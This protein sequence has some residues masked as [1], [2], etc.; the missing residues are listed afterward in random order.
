[1][2]VDLVVRNCTIVTPDGQTGPNA[3]VAVD[4]GK[5]VAVSEDDQLPDADEVIDADGAYL[6]PG[7][8]DC[9][10][11]NRSPGL[12]YK[13]DWETA[14]RAAAAGGVTTVV[15]M[16]NTDPI[17]DRPEYLQTKF[18]LGEENALVDFQAYAVITSDNL[19]QIKGLDETGVIGY[20]VFLGTTIGA[21]PPPNDGELLEAMGKVAE[22]GKRLGFH[23]END[24][25][26]THLAE[27][28]QAE[29]KNDPI[30]H[31]WSRPP[32]TERESISRTMLF[33][34]E[35]GTKIHM[36]HLSCGTGAQL[37]RDG[38]AR[39]LDVT[40]ETM[41]HYLWFT[42]DVMN[43]KGNVARIQPPIRDEE[44]RDILW[45]EVLDEDGGIDC[46]ATDHSPHTDEEKGMDDP[47]KNTWEVIS[48][49]VGLETEIPAMLTF[50]ND[51]KMSLEK[52]IEM[53]STRPAQ[54]WGMYPEKGSLQIGTDADFTIFDL[55]REWTLEDRHTLHSKNTV[56][57]FEGESF[58]GKATKT[59]VRGELVY[60][61]DQ[62]VVGEPG[63]GTRVDVDDIDNDYGEPPEERKETELDKAY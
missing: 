9:H 37:V 33:A 40:A 30:H 28:F 59:I 7:V 2:P 49:F 16:P 6:A 58:T 44:E 32:I 29:G 27:K 63:F 11:H 19:D 12:E 54:I 41:P 55:D 5:I 23:E 57:P 25:I 1:M 36:F 22:T 60:D 62:D 26:L 10:I 47:F 8:I 35:M 15:G 51:G 50:V 14:T 52:W 48:G 3:G 53:H 24:Q 18:D 61:E 46:I 17:I 31:S 38:K 45:D 20:K 56:T 4:D 43:E 13:E 34:E 42:E 21:I 39:D